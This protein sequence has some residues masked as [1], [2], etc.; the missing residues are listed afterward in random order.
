MSVYIY[1]YIHVCIYMYVH[2]CIVGCMVGHTPSARQ[3][4][5]S[6]R[7]FFFIHAYID[8]SSHEHYFLIYQ[9]NQISL[10]YLI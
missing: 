5:H 9:K 7:G 1:E 8:Q 10:S 6:H 3:V 4:A 2:T